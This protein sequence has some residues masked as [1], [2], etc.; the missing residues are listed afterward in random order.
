MTSACNKFFGGRTG[1]TD[2][3]GIWQI[4]LSSYLFDIYDNIYMHIY[5]YHIMYIMKYINI[6]SIHMSIILYI[7]FTK[8]VNLLKNH[9]SP[10][11]W[12]LAPHRGT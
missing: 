7:S 4:H 11:T 10:R 8:K 6:E 1:E 2:D 3:F 9:G 5:I 12:I